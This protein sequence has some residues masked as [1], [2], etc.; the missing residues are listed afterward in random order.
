MKAVILGGTGFIGQ[1]LIRAMECKKWDVVIPSRS[2]ERHKGLFDIRGSVEFVRWDAVNGSSLAPI[3]SGKDAV[4]NL[5]GENIAAQR[6]TPEQKTKIRE[7]RLQAGAAVVQAFAEAAQPPKVLLQA[8]AVGYYGGRGDEPLTEEDAPP[9]PGQSFLAD[10]ARDWEASTAEVERRG[11][12]RVVVRTGVV[13]D[14]GGGALEK[15]LLPFKFFVG[16]PVGGGRQWMS[17]IHRRDEAKAML[18]VIQNESCRGAFNFTAPQAVTNR[19]F[20]RTLGEVLHRPGFVPTPG[21]PLRLALGEM[22][23]ELLLKG[24]RVL[25]KKLEASGYEFVFPELRSALR[26]ILLRRR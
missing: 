9:A 11:V 10:V 15:M 12:R 6:W 20:A 13:L 24:Q 19:E 4:I 26:E 16:G 5:V 3:I 22:A 2:P 18:H 25:P 21:L 1:E 23:E 17:W 14:A 7:S 8:S